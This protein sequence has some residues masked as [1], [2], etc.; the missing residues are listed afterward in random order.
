MEGE[1]W[2]LWPDWDT[3]R[4][5]QDASLGAGQDTFVESPVYPLM[6]WPHKENHIDIKSSHQPDQ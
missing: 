5:D 2:I 1:L 4:R 6:A 3:K